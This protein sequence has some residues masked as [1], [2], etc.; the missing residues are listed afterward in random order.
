MSA[1]ENHRKALALAL[2]NDNALFSSVTAASDAFEDERYDD[3]IPIYQDILN[4]SLEPVVKWFVQ[5]KMGYSYLRRVFDSP[6]SDS[7]EE[8]IKKGLTLISEAANN[9]DVWAI[10]TIADVLRERNM[11]AD[12]R[13]MY[14]IGL[15]IGS[16][17]CKDGLAEL[18]GMKG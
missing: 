6:E 14:T 11:I 7:D 2:F 1:H 10:E 17:E 13:R 15:L 4:T 8:D 3:S 16:E 18:A 12:A 5:A 9:G